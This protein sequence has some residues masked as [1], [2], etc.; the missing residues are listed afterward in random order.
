MPSTPCSQGFPSHDEVAFPECQIAFDEMAGD[1]NLHSESP[2]CYQRTPMPY[3]FGVETSGPD[4]TV[5][6]DAEWQYWD[7][8][9][10]QRS[11]ALRLSCNNHNGMMPASGDFS[12]ALESSLSV[13]SSSRN[14]QQMVNSAPLPGMWPPQ[15]MDPLHGLPSISFNNLIPSHEDR[16][17]N[18]WVSVH[19]S[20]Q[21]VTME[22]AI[23][24]TISPADAFMDVEGKNYVLVGQD[25]LCDGMGVSPPSTPDCVDADSDV[26][27]VKVECDSPLGR[28]H[29]LRRAKKRLDYGVSSTGGKTVKKE[30]R[31]PSGTTRRKR[32][33][34]CLQRFIESN[35]TQ[36]EY[37]VVDGIEKPDGSIS[38]KGQ[39][40]QKKL[41]CQKP[42]C[43]KVFQ[44][45]EHLNRHMKTHSGEKHFTCPICDRDFNRNDNRGAHY[46]THVERAK[47]GRNKSFSMEKLREKI[48]EVHEPQEAAKLIEKLQ[49]KK[50]QEERKGRPLGCKA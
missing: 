32:E 13:H 9:D 4:R 45:A 18:D 8:P 31:S 33:N 26:A 46:L 47:Q 36:I 19:L 22:E 23:P 3:R 17:Y 50:M 15:H 44:R 49:K 43:T 34:R 25:D 28:Q 39:S 7:Q 35:G 14:L 12:S 38:I 11:N 5:H 41:P 2:G 16:V 30:R 10:F 6:A 40:Q 42:G 27:S 24:H 29:S 21:A 20:N 37:R 1:E 48:W